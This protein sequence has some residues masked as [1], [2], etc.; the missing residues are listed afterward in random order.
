MNARNLREVKRRQ[1]KTHTHT[2]MNKVTHA[3]IRILHMWNSYNMVRQMKIWICCCC[4][5]CTIVGFWNHFSRVLCNV[6]LSYTFSTYSIALILYDI[7]FSSI[8][9]LPCNE[10]L[11]DSFILCIREFSLGISRVSIDSDAQTMACFFLYCPMEIIWLLR[12]KLNFNSVLMIQW[13]RMSNFIE[14][15]SIFEWVKELFSPIPL[16]LLLANEKKNLR[17]DTSIIE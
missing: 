17:L 11:N 1:G 14:G 6:I 7:S 4:F 3:C 8:I 16:F 13:V 15:L 9:S 2:H 10:E 5:R 12:F